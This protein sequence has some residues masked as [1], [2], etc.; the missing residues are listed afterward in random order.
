MRMEHEIKK[1]TEIKSIFDKTF[2][3]EKNA[4]TPTVLEY[5]EI[6]SDYVYELSRGKG[7]SGKQYMF[8]VTIVDKN[9]FETSD[10]STGGFGDFGDAREY[11]NSLQNNS[12]KI[13]SSF[14]DEEREQ[15]PQSSSPSL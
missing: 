9:L 15:I 4:L 14:S 10:L 5:G 13:E 7:M 1:Y 12:K 6:E 3:R 2:N 11:I 8:G